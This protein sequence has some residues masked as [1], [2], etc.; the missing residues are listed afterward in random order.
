[1]LRFIVFL[2]IIISQLLVRETQKQFVI[3]QRAKSH[4]LPYSVSISV[5]TKPLQLI[6]SDVWGPAPTS[7]GR[8]QYY[9]SFIGD[10]SK[11]HALVNIHGSI[12]IYMFQVFHN[13]QA[14]VEQKFDSEIIVV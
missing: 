10:F 14:L 12:F 1:M 9:V 7:V 13:F 6:F 11:Y 5:S 2:V 8:H 3:P 4:Q